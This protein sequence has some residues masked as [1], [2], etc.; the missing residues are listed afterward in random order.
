MNNNKT[1]E[2]LKLIDKNGDYRG[3]VVIP[4]GI[5]FPARY[6]QESISDLYG[7]YGKQTTDIDGLKYDFEYDEELIIE[8]KQ[9]GAFEKFFDVESPQYKVLERKYLKH[10]DVS[11]AVIKKDELKVREILI[12][13]SNGHYAHL[14]VREADGVSHEGT[15]KT[16]M[17]LW[18]F[19]LM[20]KKKLELLSFKDT[21]KQE[22]R[23]LDLTVLHTDGA[24]KLAYT[25]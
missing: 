16:I 17:N 23:K 10:G 12:F 22:F 5:K 3:N 21:L 24:F 11:V 25:L 6:L 7:L 14:K 8:E 9:N 2:E 19:E 20:K 18:K 4:A 1:Y 15:I 13:F